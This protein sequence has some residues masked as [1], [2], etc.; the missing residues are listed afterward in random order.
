MRK[1]I[2]RREVHSSYAKKR[3]QR[4]LRG[5]VRREGE[6]VDDDIPFLTAHDP[7][8]CAE[9]ARRMCLR[10]APSEC[11]LERIAGWSDAFAF[12]QKDSKLNAARPPCKPTSPLTRRRLCAGRPVDNFAPKG[13]V[14]RK[15]VVQPPKSPPK[16]K[17][18]LYFMAQRAKRLKATAPASPR[19]QRRKLPNLRQPSRV[20]AKQSARL[21]RDKFKAPAHDYVRERVNHK[22]DVH[23]GRAAAT[24]DDHA[25]KK[26]L[27]ASQHDVPDFVHDNIRDYKLRPDLDQGYRIDDRLD[28]SL[29]PRHGGDVKK[30]DSLINHDYDPKLD[31][32]THAV[33]D[34]GGKIRHHAARNFV[35]ENIDMPWVKSMEQQNTSPVAATLTHLTSPKDADH[36][37]DTAHPTVYKDR[38]NQVRAIQDKVETLHDKLDKKK[39]ALGVQSDLRPTPPKRRVGF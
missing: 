24:V 3:R 9:T 23:K 13:F 10:S 25:S 5:K 38:Q 34:R 39:Q 31:A 32:V 1:V 14:D 18:A 33:D 12:P 35:G 19:D 29:A 28:E 15:Y 22:H 36:V 37:D 26:A 11:S 8:I 16:P 2:A 4:L 27:A 17:D 6:P 21:L 30:V 20:C 7:T